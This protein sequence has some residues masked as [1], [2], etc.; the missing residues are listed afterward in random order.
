M[1][2]HLKIIIEKLENGDMEI[3]EYNKWFRCRIPSCE[4]CFF[5][6]HASHCPTNYNEFTENL[7]ELTKNKMPELFI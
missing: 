2:K 3:G 4:G 1:N 6:K 5:Y 7:M